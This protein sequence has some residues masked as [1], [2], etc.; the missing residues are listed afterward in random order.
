L[1]E[2]TELTVPVKKYDF[3]DYYIIA[4]KSINKISIY[5]FTKRNIEN[6][7]KGKDYYFDDDVSVLN[8]YEYWKFKK[9]TSLD[10][11]KIPM[12]RIVI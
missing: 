5:V 8:R 12:K 4:F 7:K 9:T 3:L 2:L 1:T 11:S 6:L 10:I